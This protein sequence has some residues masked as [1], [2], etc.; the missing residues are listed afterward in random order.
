M[1]GKQKAKTNIYLYIYFHGNI[2]DTSSTWN[3]SNMCGCDVFCPLDLHLILF[4]C[5]IYSQLNPA[6]APY[7]VQCSYT[8]HLSSEY[9]CNTSVLKSFFTPWHLSATTTTSTT[10]SNPTSS[11]SNA[12]RTT[13][14]ICKYSFH[15]TC[16]DV[17][18]CVCVCMCRIES[19]T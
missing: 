1:Q 16:C 2:V 19:F 12:Q 13:S 9:I 3:W 7:N 17:S 18:V 5:S 4:C 8:K 14:K 10:I 15:F 6:L 11:T